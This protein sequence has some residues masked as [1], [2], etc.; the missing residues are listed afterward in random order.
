VAAKQDA[1]LPRLLIIEVGPE[2]FKLPPATQRSLAQRWRA[3]WT[4]TVAQGIV[5]VLAQDTDQP[6]VEYRANGRIELL[7]KPSPPALSPAAK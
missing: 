1:D 7:T 6:V 5:A 2:W 4:H 3:L